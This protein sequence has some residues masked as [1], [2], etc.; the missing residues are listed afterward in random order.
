MR[1]TIQFH[2]NIT[3]AWVAFATTENGYIHIPRVGDHLMF[4][5]VRC[6]VRE[7]CT[8]YKQ[9]ET[10]HWVYVS[11]LTHRVLGGPKP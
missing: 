3:G 11:R 6:D 2:D 4:N 1:T 9:D 10:E 8:V 7:V 5:D